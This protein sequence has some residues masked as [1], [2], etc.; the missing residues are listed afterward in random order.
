MYDTEKSPT[1]NLI[2]LAKRAAKLAADS[3]ALVQDLAVAAS[4]ETVSLDTAAPMT[5]AEISEIRPVSAGWLKANVVA[6]GR[7]KRQ[8]L[9]YLVSDVD[10][11]LQANPVAPR[12]RKC[13]SV[14]DCDPLD[15]M[16]RDGTLVRGGR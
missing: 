4:Q 13:A 1:V 6:R 9:V 8:Q 3:A 14:D 7:G 12:P 16:L 10:A 15:A 2:E 5:A 11:V